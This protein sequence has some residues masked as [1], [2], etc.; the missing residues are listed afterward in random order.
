M[1]RVVCIT[2]RALAAHMFLRL[3][4][5]HSIYLTSLSG[6][7]ASSYDPLDTATSALSEMFCFFVK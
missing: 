7:S 1:S 5:F 3:F 6:R 2:L 4:L